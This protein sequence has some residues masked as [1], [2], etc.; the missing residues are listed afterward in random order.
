MRFWIITSFP[1]FAWDLYARYSLCSLGKHLPQGFKLCVALDDDTLYQ[2]VKNVWVEGGDDTNFNLS[3]N[4]MIDAAQKN[5]EKLTYA[6]RAE[7]EII[8][9][10]DDA[11][12]KFI[13]QNR[14]KDHASDY[15]LQATRFA[16][17]IFFLKRFFD[18]AED[19]ELKDKPDYIIWWDADALLTKEIQ[20]NDFEMIMPRDDEAVSYL[21]RKDWDHSECGFMAFNMAHHGAKEIIDFMITY[22]Q[23]NLIF[24]LSQ[25]HDS[26]LFDVARKNFEDQGQK[27]LNLSENIKGNNVWAHTPL[28]GFSEHWK[29][30]EAKQRKK[31][32]TDDELFIDNKKIA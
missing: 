21:G 29:G 32:L 6:P 22:Y 8:C 13:N 11:H 23:Q 17:K 5:M 12:A 31:P 3:Q 25:W 20:C 7:I 27:N 16:H 26:Y 28:G 9:G 1:N 24:S 2:S 4:V 14:H 30:V 15:R 19:C 18:V 10:W